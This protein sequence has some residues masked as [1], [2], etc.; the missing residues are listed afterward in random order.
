MKPL[1]CALATHRE[2]EE[3]ITQFKGMASSTLPEREAMPEIF[4]A[5]I[6]ND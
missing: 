2:I 3:S 6:K 4:N 5:K 1:R